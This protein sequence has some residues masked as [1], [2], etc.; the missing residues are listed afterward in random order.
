MR[1]I[2]LNDVKGLYPTKNVA[3]DLRRTIVQNKL[4]SHLLSGDPR[5]NDQENDE[6]F[7]NI[8]PQANVSKDYYAF[9]SFG[10]GLGTQGSGL[11]GY[12]RYYRERF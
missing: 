2:L 9:F 3:L 7:S 6:L 8:F 4:V 11:S 5:F 1:A 12:P 10:R